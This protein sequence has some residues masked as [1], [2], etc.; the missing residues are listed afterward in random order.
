MR[1]LL[2]AVAADE[3]RFDDLKERF[4]FVGSDESDPVA[5]AGWR[6]RGIVP[7]HYDTS[8][9]DHEVLLRLLQRWADLSAING[10]QR[11]VHREIR[12]PREVK[13]G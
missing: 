7:I 11:I 10:K 12:L 2:N 5:L 8:G 3:G 6:A 4:I 9:R 13:Q 1:Y